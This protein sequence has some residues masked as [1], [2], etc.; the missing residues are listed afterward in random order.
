MQIMSIVA[1]TTFGEW[2]R[3][4]NGGDNRRV[5]TVA[6]ASDVERGASTALGV[7]GVLRSTEAV[8]AS[9]AAAIS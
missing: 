3:S 1:M 2:P 7:A 8:R 4:R 9:W 5:A 6:T